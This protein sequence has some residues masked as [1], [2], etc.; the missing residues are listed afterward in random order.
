MSIA[1][2][3]A[4]M[5]TNLS[6]AY[7]KIND[8]GG[9]LPANKNLQN[10]ASAIDSIQGGGGVSTQSQNIFTG[11]TAPLTYLN[12]TNNAFEYKSDT[13]NITITGLDNISTIS[14]NGTKSVTVTISTSATSNSQTPFTITCVKDTETLIYNGIAFHYGSVLQSGY[15]L[16]VAKTATNA[17]PDYIFIES[18]SLPTFAGATTTWNDVYAYQIINIVL[19]N[20]ATFI[21]QNFLTGCYSFNQPITLPNTVT[22]IQDYFLSN[23]HSFNQPITFSTGL[24]TI[25]SYFLYNCYSFNQPL[26]LPN[27][28]TSIGDYFLYGCQ[29][30]NQPLVIPSGV[31]RIQ[32]Y[33]MSGCSAFNKSLTLPS[34]LASIGSN[35]LS[36]NYAFNQ[37]LV[38][39][40]GVTTLNERFLNLCTAFNQPLTLSSVTYYGNYFM[41]S[42]KSFNQPLSI[43]AARTIGTN[44]MY[45]CYAFAQ[46]LIIPNT[47]TSIN[48]NFMKDCYSFIELEYNSSKYPTDSNSL[49]QIVNSKTSSTGTGI[50]VTGTNASGLK[51]S[52]PDR[53]ATPYRKLVLGS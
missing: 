23:C 29:S 32:T 17:T 44:F 43:P 47:V 5:Q 36:A 14:G 33:F 40:S 18:N 3:I 52:L 53:T 9:T 46:K 35:F 31:T 49:S 27:T 2:T 21:G 42:C 16:A 24:T 7:A 1:S 34:N 13:H 41:A 25:Y 51:S 28:V 20:N 39:P 22:S 50:I 4:S 37:P 26:E 30:F 45:Y 6:N 19:P 48:T 10:L 38:I 8:K 15:C 12:S 11:A